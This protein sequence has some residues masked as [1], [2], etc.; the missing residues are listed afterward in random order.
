MKKLVQDTSVL[1]KHWR[2]SRAGTLSG[3]TVADV[4][5]WAR[6]LIE[7]QGTNAILT[8][9][10]IEFVCGVT[11]RHE[12]NLAHAY[13]DQFEIIDQGDI[14]RADWI[15]ARRMAERIPAE[16]SRRGLVDCLIKAI[17][18]RLRREVQT[19]DLGM[20]RHHPNDLK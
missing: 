14:T 3:T 20:P 7:T 1:I 17:A 4:G 11:N 13:L 8:P 2:N 16:S 10:Y 6:S 18:V 5:I 12:M 15:L 9:I 19:F